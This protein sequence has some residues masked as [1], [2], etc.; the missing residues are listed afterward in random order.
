[1]KRTN[2]IL[3]HIVKGTPTSGVPLFYTDA[4]KSEKILYNQEKEIKWFKALMIQLKKERIE[5]YAILTVFLD[6]PEPLNI[7]T[8]SQYAK[9]VV[10]HI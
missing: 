3:P 8:D 1:M 6:F 9:R 10:L 5:L 4:N 2:W 7:V